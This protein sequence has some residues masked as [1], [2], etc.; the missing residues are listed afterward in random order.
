[1]CGLYLFATLEGVAQK[2]TVFRK[3]LSCTIFPGRFSVMERPHCQT[4][5]RGFYYAIDFRFLALFFQP[6]QKLSWL[7]GILKGERE[8]VAIVAIPCAGLRRG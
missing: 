8:Y 2:F 7:R 3:S 1:M 5:A 6:G 4:L